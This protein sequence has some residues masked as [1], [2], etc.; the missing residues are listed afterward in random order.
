MPAQYDGLSAISFTG[1]YVRGTNMK[2]GM[3][4]GNGN[5]GGIQDE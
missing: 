4:S 3:I 1:N 5:A 2:G